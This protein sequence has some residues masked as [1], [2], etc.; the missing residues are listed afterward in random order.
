[1]SILH[2]LRKNKYNVLGFWFLFLQLLV[3]FE[4]HVVYKYNIFFWF[5]DHAPLVISFAFFSKNKDLLKS[6]I[7]F[8]FLVQFVWIID[9]LFKIIFDKN[10]LGVTNYIFTAKLGFLVLIPLVI[11]SLCINVAFLH[12]YKIKPTIKVLI[13]SAIYV[14]MIYALSLTYTPIERN[15]NCIHEICGL[16]DYTFSS[17][18]YFWPLL[19]FIIIILPTQGIQW[20]VYKWSRKRKKDKEIKK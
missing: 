7:N 6:M 15:V 16:N 4:N 12:T 20:W 3:F 19:V 9:F 8:G 14:M 18:T 11:H 10:F 13:Y 2:W 5:C 17:Y 1:M